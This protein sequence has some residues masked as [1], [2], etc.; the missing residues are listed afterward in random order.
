MGIHYD[1]KSTRGDKKCVSNRNESNGD[2][3]RRKTMSTSLATRY[4]KTWS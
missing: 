2:A 1:Y 4:P 3:E